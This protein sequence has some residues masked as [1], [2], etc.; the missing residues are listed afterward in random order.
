MLSAQ[1]CL[2]T[3]AHGLVGNSVQVAAARTLVRGIRDGDH[4]V[5]QANNSWR[6]SHG[7]KDF[8]EE[9]CR[10]KR[11]G[12][13]RGAGTGVDEPEDNSHQVFVCPWCVRS[14]WYTDFQGLLSVELQLLYAH[15]RHASAKTSGQTSRLQNRLLTAMQS[16]EPLLY[17]MIYR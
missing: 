6:D 7:I 12:I 11:A 14:C 2:S 1:H 15:L 4:T 16:F 3:G 13:H 5:E 8:E 10:L 9:L 17:Y